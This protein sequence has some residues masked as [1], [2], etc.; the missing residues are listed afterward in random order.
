MTGNIAQLIARLRLCGHGYASMLD[1]AA[2]ALTALTKERDA[3]EA[4]TI[5]RC[6]HVAQFHAADGYPSPDSI[7]HAIRT[8][9][10]IGAQPNA[11][12]EAP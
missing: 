3:I 6:A 2:A 4:R 11:S 7:A 8:I 9:R 5:E 10:R 12:S 1:E